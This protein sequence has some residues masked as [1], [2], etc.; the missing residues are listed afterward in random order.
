MTL[1]ITNKKTTL[2]GNDS[3]IHKLKKYN[4]QTKLQ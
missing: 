2:F 3:D 4:Y 1:L